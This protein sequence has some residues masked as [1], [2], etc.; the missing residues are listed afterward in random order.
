MS[1]WHS[2]QVVR[3]KGTL[4]YIHLFKIELLIINYS[5]MISLQKNKFKEGEDKIG[6]EK[7]A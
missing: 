1:A 7:N 3:T 2:G 4:P 6:I 5:R